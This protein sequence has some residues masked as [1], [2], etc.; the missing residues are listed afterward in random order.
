MLKHSFVASS[1]TSSSYD[2]DPSFVAQMD[3]TRGLIDGQDRAYI[4][5]HVHARDIQDSRGLPQGDPQA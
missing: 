1:A 4:L 5:I 2:S 3:C